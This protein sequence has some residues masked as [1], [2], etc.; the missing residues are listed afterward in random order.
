[1]RIVLT[2]D[3]APEDVDKNSA[4]GVTNEA[5]ERILNAL[6]GA[7]LDDVDIEKED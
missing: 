1:V 4:T 5:H 7:G 6:Y 3:V 2:A